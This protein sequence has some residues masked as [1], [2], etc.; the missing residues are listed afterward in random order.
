MATP[1][2]KENFSS[3]IKV[4]VEAE[5]IGILEAI[6]DECETTGLEVELAATLLNDELKT[7]LASEAAMF[8][9]IKKDPP[10]AKKK[11]KKKQ[12]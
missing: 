10:L 2:E 12:A 3:K 7:K 1:T 11:T 8:N 5:N 9:L 6:M 4:R